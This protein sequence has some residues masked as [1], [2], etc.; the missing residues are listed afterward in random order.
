[1]ER[2]DGVAAGP[3]PLRRGSPQREVEGCLRRSLRHRIGFVNGRRSG[4]PLDKGDESRVGA[5]QQDLTS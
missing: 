5:G 2:Q 3:L 1:M 4:H